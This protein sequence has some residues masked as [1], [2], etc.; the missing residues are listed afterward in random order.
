MAV[1]KNKIIVGATRVMLHDQGLP[2]QLWDKACN[3]TIYVY[4]HSPHQILEMK[5]PEVAYPGK[6]PYVGHFRI[7][8][9]SAYFH[10]SKYAWKKLELRTKLGMF[11]G[12]T[13]TPHNYWVYLSTSRMT[14]VFKDF[15]FDEEKAMGAS[16]ERELELHVNEEIL[17]PKVEKPQI[18]VE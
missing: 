13:D 17:A 12:Y 6:R 8:G 3:T 15:I 4:N 16:L 11:L 9:S 1:R 18:Y 10:V 14:V 7:F 2:L 5:T